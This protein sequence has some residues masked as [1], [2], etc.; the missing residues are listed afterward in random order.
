MS[1]SSSTGLFELDENL[2]VPPLADVDRRLDPAAGQIADLAGLRLDLDVLGM[3]ACRIRLWNR[4]D[5]VAL[6]L[7]DQIVQVMPVHGGLRPGFEFHLPN[8]DPVVLEQE[9]GADV[10]EDPMCLAHV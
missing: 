3:L 2:A 9:G 5:P 7:H 1:P 8:A 10:P 6:D 4:R